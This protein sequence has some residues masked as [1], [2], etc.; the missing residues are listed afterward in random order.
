[1]K[2]SKTMDELHN[3]REEMSKMTEEE[4]TELLNSVREKYKSL[5]YEKDLI[6]K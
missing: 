3:I 1:M 2:T 6:K 5:I 4:K